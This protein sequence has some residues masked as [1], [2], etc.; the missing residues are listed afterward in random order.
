VARFLRD[1]SSVS[2]TATNYVQARIVYTLEAALAAWANGARMGTRDMNK[3]AG[4][5]QRSFQEGGKI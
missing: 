1:G 4:T 2:Q 3:S 5:P